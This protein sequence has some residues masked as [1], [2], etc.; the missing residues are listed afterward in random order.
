MDLLYQ[1]GL[2]LIQWL[3]ENYPQLAG[4]FTAISALASPEFFLATIPLIYWAIDKR[5]GRLLGYVLFTA[6]AVNTIFKQAFRSPRPF[7]LEPS[8]GIVES[9]GYGLPSAHAQNAAA[10]FLLAAGWIRRK[11]VWFLAIVLVLLIGLSRIYLGEHFL[12]DVIGGFLLGAIIL[13]VIY[14]YRRYLASFFAKRILGQQLL[15]VVLVAFCLALAYI[16]VVMIIGAPNLA[17]PWSQYIPEAEIESMRE[18]AR[19]FG[20]MLGYSIGIVLENVRIRFRADGPIGKR[21]AR[22]FLGIL[23]TVIIW[24]GL[25]RIFPTDPLWLGI[26]L[27]FLQYMIVGLW[28]SYYAPSLFV[29]LKLADADPEPKI[30]FRL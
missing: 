27:R 10:L 4:F 6:V 13:A 15:A 21:T 9:P 14:L 19:T 22:Y 2:E 23:L 25:D 20:V 29:R 12:I 3:Q 16:A 17:V 8:V 11:S 1:Q 18:M 7:W 5:L 28:V 26:P 30:S 24:Q